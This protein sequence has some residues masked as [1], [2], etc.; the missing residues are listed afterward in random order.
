ML[1][2]TLVNWRP[3]AILL[4]QNM[5]PFGTFIMVTLHSMLVYSIE[6]VP[7]QSGVPLAEATIV[8][9]MVI[10]KKKRTM[11]MMTATVTMTNPTP[12]V[13]TGVLVNMHTMDLIHLSHLS[14]LSLARATIPIRILR[15]PTTTKKGVIRIPSRSQRNQRIPN[16]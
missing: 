15:S 9:Q 6:F 16:L 12:T 3:P 5:L 1:L 13:P 10:Q 14:H 8:I 7:R 2:N 11:M 4:S